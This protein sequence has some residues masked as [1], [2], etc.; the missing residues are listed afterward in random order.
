MLVWWIMPQQRFL[1]NIMEKLNQILIFLQSILKAKVVHGQKFL[2]H[3]DLFQV[4]LPK[5]LI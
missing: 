1:S 5:P 3:Q 4:G 2:K